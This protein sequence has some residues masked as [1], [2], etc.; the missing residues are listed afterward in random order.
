MRTR[1]GKC[2][3]GEE[4]IRIWID[5]GNSPHVALFG[6]VVDHLRQRGD[7]IF[8]TARDH[9]QTVELAMERWPDIVVIGSGSPKAL[10]SKAAAVGRRARDLA[11]LLKEENPDVALSHGSY[12]QAIAAK[13]LGVPL[14]TMMDY[15][16][17]PANHLSFRLARRVIVPKVFPAPALR[18]FG[19]RGPKVL[20][21]NGFKEQLYLARFCPKEDVIDQLGL[22]REKII[23]V[24]R[25]APEGALYHRMANDR[26]DELLEIVRRRPDIDAVLLPRSAD[27]TARYG[28]L[29]GVT[30]PDHPIDA[31]SLLASADLTIGAGGTMTRESALLGTATYTVFIGRPGAVDAEL[32]RL[33]LL[34]DLRAQ[35]LPV[36]AKRKERGKPSLKGGRAEILAAIRTGLAQAG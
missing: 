13:R 7:D 34:H 11:R 1:E 3:K 9:A 26:F 20:R 15:E 18:R 28:A 6:E 30:V 2:R 27:D 14:V 29:A 8:L 16:H 33:G 17:Q 19:A 21:Y 22:D 36:F 31:L 4:T 12:A 10:R 25:P 32:M 5:L 23:V 24:M 35:G